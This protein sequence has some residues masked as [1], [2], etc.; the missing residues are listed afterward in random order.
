MD[1]LIGHLNCGLPKQLLI[2]LLLL[3]YPYKYTKISSAF[4]ESSGPVMELASTFS[5]FSFYPT[6]Q[7]QGGHLHLFQFHSHCHF[8]LFYSVFSSN[9]VSLCF[10][11]V[12]CQWWMLDFLLLWSCLGP[13]CHLIATFVCDRAP[14][15]CHHCIL[16]GYLLVTM[17]LSHLQQLITASYLIVF[18]QLYIDN[19]SQQLYSCP[20]LP[21]LIGFTFLTKRFIYKDRDS[22]KPFFVL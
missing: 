12:Q 5:S 4:L 17:Q 10:Q 22:N 15:C 18:K 21:S 8:K 7:F 1:F 6:S 9:A 14:C 20:S 3:Y 16:A 11:P 2:L 13:F 19:V